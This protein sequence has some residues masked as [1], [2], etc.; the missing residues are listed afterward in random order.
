MCPEKPSKKCVDGFKWF[1][2]RILWRAVS[3]KEFL[4]RKELLDEISNHCFPEENPIPCRWLLL[5]FNY[6]I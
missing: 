5:K 1:R 6:K 3:R 4:K 2:G